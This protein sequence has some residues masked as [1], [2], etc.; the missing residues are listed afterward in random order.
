MNLTGDVAK[1]VPFFL[2]GVGLAQDVDG[3]DGEAEVGNDSF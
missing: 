3:G 1:S 2:D